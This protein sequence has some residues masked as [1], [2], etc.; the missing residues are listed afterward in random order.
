MN[1][2]RDID[3]LRAYAVIAAVLFHFGCLPNGFLGVDIFFVISGF[4]ITRIISNEI[5][6]ERFSITDF[7]IRRI[8]RIVP[9]VLFVSFCSLLLG[10]LVMLPDD[11]ENLAQSVIA[12]NLF[13]NNIL[14]VLT[15]KDYWDVVNEFKP[16]M[17]TWSL[18]IEAQFYLCY[19]LLLVLF[20]KLRFR[21]IDT[22]R[23]NN[24]LSFVYIINRVS[25][26]MSREL[27]PGLLTLPILIVLTVFS[28]GLFF[29]PFEE[30][31]KF[32]VLPF[33]F[34]ELSLGGIAALLSLK[35]SIYAKYS[36]VSVLLLLAVCCFDI[37]FISNEILVIV[38]AAFTSIVLLFS[39]AQNHI[40]SIILENRVV[41][42]LGK[43]SFGIYMW[44]QVVLAFTRYFVLQEISTIQYLVIFIL[45][46]LLA[47][48]TYFFIEQPCRYKIT[49]KRLIVIVSIAI[50][51]LSGV[52]LD[53]FYRS[54]VIRDVPELG[55]KKGFRQVG[56]HSAYNSSV[57]EYDVDFTSND[58]L[59]ILVVG[60]SFARDWC[61]VLLESRFSHLIELAYIEDFADKNVAI[62]AKKADYISV[63]PCK[64]KRIRNSCIDESK[65]WCVGTKSFG[66]NN[67]YF[68]NYS[69]ED[70]CL[71][72]TKISHRYIRKNERLKK[73][74]E[75]RYI[76]LMA[77]V[78]DNDK[79]VPV[80]TQD[81]KFI[82]QDT[83]HFTRYGSE[84]FARLIE[85]S[86]EFPLNNSASN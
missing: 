37:S 63:S 40:S 32:Y 16:L 75:N 20:S 26:H 43:I 74:W 35:K 86:P 69:G 19:P 33:R 60:N 53:I 48:F 23:R 70:Y 41:V 15:T 6:T 56:I 68:Y 54:G 79:K 34:F 80:F 55:L 58:K 47:T 1:Y 72:R 50:L 5:N 2:R 22:A 51:M 65:T 78:I 57:F 7:Y 62:R 52:S 73:E 81:C 67:G 11:L 3:G 4:L 21:F 64:K 36:F 61:N 66:V 27:T 12:T 71:Q 46:I 59:K 83:R 10:A 84:Y 44:H 24:S 29:M 39:N 49:T 13:S 14:Q 77:L 45:T 31:I 82:S 18:G 9:L 76:D 85:K 8:K 28:A 42:F 30:H 38:T 25:S 17:H